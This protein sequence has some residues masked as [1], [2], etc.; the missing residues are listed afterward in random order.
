VKFTVASP[1]FGEMGA[2]NSA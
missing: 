1:G 2:Q